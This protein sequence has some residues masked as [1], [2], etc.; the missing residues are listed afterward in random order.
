M[1][2]FIVSSTYFG[3]VLSVF[4]YMIGLEVK[5]KLKLGIFNPLLIGIIVVISVLLLTKVDYETYNQSAKYLTYLLTP[6]TICLAVPL[7]EK[8]DILKK[9]YKAIIIGITTGIFTSFITVLVIS[10]LFS[11]TFEQYITLIP[12]SITTAIGMD[13]SSEFGGV[14]SLTAATITVTGVFGNVFAPKILSFFKITNPVSKGLAIG[15]SA[16]ALG[17][18]KA[19]ELGEVEG[20]I[21]GLAIAVS[22]LITV[23]AVN[24]FAVVY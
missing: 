4:A 16:H 22:G 5:K 1:S 7:Y 15:T 12:K 24:I 10:R 13:L 14:R 21:S 3:L 11:L 6:A 18:S 19:I 8:L 17:T 20:A 2:E 23:V 9:D